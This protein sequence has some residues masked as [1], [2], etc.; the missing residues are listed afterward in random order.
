MHRRGLGRGILLVVCL[1]LFFL[2]GTSAYNLSQISIEP[3][4]ALIPGTPILVSGI[5][6]FPLSANKSFEA[7]HVLQLSTDLDNP[8]WTYAIVV[9]GIEKPRPYVGGSIFAISGFEL[10]WEKASVSLRFNLEGKTP[11]VNQTLNKTPIRIQEVDEKGNVVDNSTFEYP[12]PVIYYI[13]RHPPREEL[14]DRLETFRKHIDEKVMIGVNVSMAE[15]KYHDAQQKIASARVRP[16]AQYAEA[17]NELKAAQNAIVDGEKALDKAWA[18]KEAADAQVNL[19][20][21]DGIIDW[22]LGNASTATDYPLKSYIAERDEASK[23]LASATGD[24]E[25][26]NYSLARSKAEE[27]YGKAS[28]SYNNATSRREQ[29]LTCDFCGHSQIPAGIFAIAAGIASIALLIGGIIWWKKRKAV[30][31]A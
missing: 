26:G 20:K 24:I 5:I 17:L 14:P 12:V 9:D 22:F 8:R 29:L 18:E 19:K 30:K 13:E 11:S 23:I 21:A 7:G 2:Q 4:G 15:E 3:L 1:L 28:G 6:D 27:A 10:S 25:N 31:Q 16:S